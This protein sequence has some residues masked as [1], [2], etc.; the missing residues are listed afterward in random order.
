MVHSTG[1]SDWNLSHLQ[2]QDCLYHQ[3][4]DEIEQKKKER[5]EKRIRKQMESYSYTFFQ[6][7][8]RFL[9]EIIFIL[10]AFFTNRRNSTKIGSKYRIGPNSHPL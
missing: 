4:L 10:N 7:L 5:K 3:A 2:E 9:I 6:I 1:E 8:I